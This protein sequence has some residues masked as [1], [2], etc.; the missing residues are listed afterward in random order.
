MNPPTSTVFATNF[1]KP[2][3][4]RDIRE[5]FEPFGH[6][7]SVFISGYKIHKFPSQCPNKQPDYYEDRA[8]RMIA[9]I[10]YSS[11]EEA[12]E[13]INAWKSGLLRHLGL[14]ARLDYEI[15]S[16]RNNSEPFHTLRI[17]GYS[18]GPPVLEGIAEKFK[19]HVWRVSH[20]QLS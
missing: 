4:E 3:L 16:A 11:V 10:E 18:G 5:A 19:D 2:I 9:F 15:D 20:R 14:R 1:A 17:S 8:S 6:V 13:A 12:T 7:Q